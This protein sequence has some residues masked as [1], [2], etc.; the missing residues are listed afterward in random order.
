M[1]FNLNRLTA[2]ERKEFATLKNEIFGAD[3]FVV[4][5][6]SDPRQQRYDLLMAKAMG[7]GR[8]CPV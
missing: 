7:N 3:M 2:R 5:D 6:F 8:P 1:R 4:P